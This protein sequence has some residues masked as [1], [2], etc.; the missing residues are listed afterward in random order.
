MRPCEIQL[1]RLGQLEKFVRNTKI[2]LLVS[3]FAAAAVIVFGKRVLA[4]SPEEGILRVRGIVIEDATGHPRI[5]IG[6][7]ISNQGRKR[8][9][10]VT[11]LILLKN[12][13]TDRLTIGT[14][15]YDQKNGVLQHRIANGVGVLLNDAKGNERGGFGILDNGRVTLGLD[16]ANGEEGAFLTVEDEDDFAGLVIKNAHTCNVASFGNSKDVETRLL[17]RDRACND[18]VRLGITDSAAPKLEV[19]DNQEKLVFDAF[20]KPHR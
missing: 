18:R 1:E 4:S 17:L 15:D 14:A 5:L 8:Q 7:P 9:D 10:E 16:R 2:L 11:G 6:A 13:G 20:A 12:D 3:V 19:Q